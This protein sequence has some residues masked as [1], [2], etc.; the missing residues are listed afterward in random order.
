MAQVKS[1]PKERVQTIVLNDPALMRGELK[2]VGG[3][4]WDM[5]NNQLVS[6]VASAT[7][8]GNADEAGKQQR[9]GGAVAGPA[10]I[11]PGD[12]IEAMLAAQMV[13]AHQAAMECYRRAM[14]QQQTF[15]GRKENLNQANKLSRTQAALTDALNKHRGKGQQ[16]GTVE[17]VHVHQGGQAI[18]GA[19]QTKGGGA[20][21]GI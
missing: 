6:Q 5:W 1:A 14:L 7:W 13:A 21:A 11:R 3:S 9:V 12:E 15:E 16:K 8:M 4:R 2:T 10:G 17:H 18:V 20:D 19:V